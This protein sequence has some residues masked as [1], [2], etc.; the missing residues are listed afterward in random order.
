MIKK[1]WILVVA[2]YARRRF[3]L[4]RFR[5]AVERFAALYT[6]PMTHTTVPM[7]TRR[8]NSHD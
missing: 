6:V 3:P 2:P 5:A 8:N 4:R 7:I 1:Q